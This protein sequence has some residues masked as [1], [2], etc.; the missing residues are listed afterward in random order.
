MKYY[1][2]ITILI[3]LISCKTETKINTNVVSKKLP[4]NKILKVIKTEKIQ[5]HIGIFTHS[6][7]GST[8][9]F[10]Y[11]FTVNNNEIIWKNRGSAIPKKIIFCKDSIF[12]K[13]LQKKS[14][15]SQQI[16]ND[17]IKQTKIKDTIIERYDQYIDNRYFFKWF[18]DVNWINISKN[19]YNS[20]KISC[21]EY[22]IPND[23]D[24]ALKE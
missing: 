18:G 15:S 21:N 16:L 22:S 1:F 9:D 19:K 17:T 6:N 10:K 24:F 13:Y 3:L 7:Y 2:K 23:N 14:I 12:I 20:K 5:T 8:Y 11:Q 4:N